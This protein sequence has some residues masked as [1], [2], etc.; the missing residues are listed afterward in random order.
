MTYFVVSLI[1]IP[2]PTAGCFVVI[3]IDMGR[4]TSFNLNVTLIAACIFQTPKTHT[5]T[6]WEH[7]RSHRFVS[8]FLIRFSRAV[9]QQP[10]QKQ[11]HQQQQQQKQKRMRF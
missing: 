5:Q 8:I 7:S 3:R 2:E 4:S 10:K 1:Y 11:R 6:H 9:L